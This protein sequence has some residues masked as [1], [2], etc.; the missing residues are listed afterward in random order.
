MFH[1][2]LGY[3]ESEELRRRKPRPWELSLFSV[4]SCLSSNSTLDGAPD[5][6]STVIGWSTL[7]TG[8]WKLFSGP[9]PSLPLS[10]VPLA[11]AGSRG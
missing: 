6:S 3:S 1:F 7:P 10:N 2:E 4:N 11:L 9:A 5:Y 8:S